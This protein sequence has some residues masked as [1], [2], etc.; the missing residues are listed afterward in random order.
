MPRKLLPRYLFI[1]VVQT[2]AVAEAEATRRYSD[3]EDVY[4]KNTMV[5]AAIDI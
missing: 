4:N 5:E 3:M 1:E 2:K